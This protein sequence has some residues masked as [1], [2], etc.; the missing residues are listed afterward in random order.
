[1][2]KGETSSLRK[3]HGFFP[4][5]WAKGS[6]G[7]L[8]RPGELL[9]NAGRGPQAEFKGQC[10]ERVHSKKLAGSR[11][12][13]LHFTPLAQRR[14]GSRGRLCSKIC[15]RMSSPAQFLGVAC[16]Q[17]MFITIQRLRGRFS[18]LHTRPALPRTG[19]RLYVW[20]RSLSRKA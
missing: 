4:G 13:F 18:R 16:S 12:A 1:M 10:L 11:I 9:V 7:C 2:G 3:L 8:G 6:A 17:G 15:L 5:N 14:E 19:H 20:S